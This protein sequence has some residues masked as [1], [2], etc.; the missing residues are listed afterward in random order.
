[1][2]KSEKQE[3][4]ESKCFL[5]THIFQTCPANCKANIANNPWLGKLDTI[6]T[7]KEKLTTF[8]MGENTFTVAVTAFLQAQPNIIEAFARENEVNQDLIRYFFGICEPE[9]IK[10]I[11]ESLSNEVIYRILDTDYKNYLEI[12]KMLGR[13]PEANNYFALKSSRY[14]HFVSGEKI[15]NL[16]VYLVKERQ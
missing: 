2:A 11:V 12:R 9:D 16:I 15:C 3:N 6:C 4:T 8:M 14:W 7:A 10:R 13:S 1:M 5:D